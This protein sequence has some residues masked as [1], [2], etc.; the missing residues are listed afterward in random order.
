MTHGM[1]LRS[2]ALL[3]TIPKAS[4]IPSAVPRKNPANVASK[5]I[6]PWY[7]N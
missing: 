6:H 1:T 2:I 7:T 4:K 3:C 5:V